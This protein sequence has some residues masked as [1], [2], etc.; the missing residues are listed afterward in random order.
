MNDYIIIFL[1]VRGDHNWII[2]IFLSK[3]GIINLLYGKNVSHKVLVL[4]MLPLMSDVVG[5]KNRENIVL[6]KDR[7]MF[8]KII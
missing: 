3:T 1:A 8:G 2:L 5:I 6:Y 4:K 7:V